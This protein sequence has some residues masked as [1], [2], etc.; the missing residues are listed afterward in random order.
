[1]KISKPESECLLDERQYYLDQKR[2]ALELPCGDLRNIQIE[3]YSQVLDVINGALCGQTKST[4][5]RIQEYLRKMEEQ[6]SN[7]MD[8]NYN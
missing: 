5:E 3:A 1:M 4:T 8:W 2:E 6:I 7:L